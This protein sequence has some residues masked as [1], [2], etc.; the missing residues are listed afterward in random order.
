MAYCGTGMQSP[1]AIVTA[2]PELYRRGYPIEQ[3]AARSSFLEVAYLLIY[4]ALPGAPQLSHFTSE[5]LLHGPVHSDAE[6]FFRAFR[7]D[8]HPMA[9]LTSAFAY[10]GSYYGEANPSLQG[11]SVGPEYLLFASKFVFLGQDLFTKAAK[12][13]AAALQNMDR[14]IFRLIGKATTLAAMAYR[15]RQGRD[16]V[17]PPTGMSYAES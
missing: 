17:V 9:M 7:Y 12:G 1:P 14:Q 2:H 8:A 5:V 4:G 11:E 16:F 15:I 6:G 3:L 13:D 10:L